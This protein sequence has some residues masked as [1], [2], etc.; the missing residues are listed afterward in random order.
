MIKPNT[1]VHLQCFCNERFKT[2]KSLLPDYLTAY[3]IYTNSYTV[4]LSLKP[5]KIV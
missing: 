4:L 1:V 5:I 3:E 2:P